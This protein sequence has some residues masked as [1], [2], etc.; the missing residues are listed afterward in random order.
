MSPAY[1]TADD[2]RQRLR[3]ACHAVG[4]QR[5]FAEQ[6]SIPTTSIWDTLHK[7]ARQPAE[8]VLAALGLRRVEA[9]YAPE[10]WWHPEHLYRD[11][12]LSAEEGCD[13]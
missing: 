4:G 12:R 11:N 10:N 5:A 8:A 2:V 9:L 1:L 7:P 13:V 3:N 6:H